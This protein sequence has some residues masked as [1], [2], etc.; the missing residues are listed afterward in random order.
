MKQA[1]K[2]QVKKPYRKP[3]VQK[4][5]DFKQ[6]TKLG[7]SKGGNLNDGLASTKLQ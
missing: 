7:Q 6:L 4:L 1:E 5:G 3:S 2:L